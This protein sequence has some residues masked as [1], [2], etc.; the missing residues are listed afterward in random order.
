MD[1]G[2]LMKDLRVQAIQ[3]NPLLPYKIAKILLP[4]YTE[5]ANVSVQVVVKNCDCLKY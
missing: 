2:K 4:P 1:V 5:V 3:G